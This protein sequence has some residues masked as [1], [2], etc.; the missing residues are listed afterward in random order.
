MT[1][2]HRSPNALGALHASSGLETFWAVADCPP[3]LA[4]KVHD[5]KARAPR[6]TS[7]RSQG[8]AR[9]GRHCSYFFEILGDMSWKGECARVAAIHYPLRHVDAGSRDIISG[10]SRRSRRS[11][12]RCECPSAL[13]I[14]GCCLRAC[15]ISSCTLRRLLRIVVK[16][17][18]HPVAGRQPNEL[19]VC[20]F[21]HSRRRQHDVGELAQPFLLLFN[22]AAW[23]NR[24]DR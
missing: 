11:P 4:V 15:A 16:N 18:R 20:C 8:R 13:Q 2:R 17:E 9:S 10:H 7:Q 5:A 19:L 14:S 6:F 1:C 12:G 23:K 21:P 22:Q 3:D 24:P